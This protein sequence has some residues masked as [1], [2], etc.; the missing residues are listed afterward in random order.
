[1]VTGYLGGATA[2]QVSHHGVA[3]LVHPFSGLES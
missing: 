2:T 1:M 3:R